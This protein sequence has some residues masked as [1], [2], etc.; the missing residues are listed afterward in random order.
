[1]K[2]VGAA[3]ELLRLLPGLAD[4][5]LSHQH[6]DQSR[7]DADGVCCDAPSLLRVKLRPRPTLFLLALAQYASSSLPS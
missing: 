2:D 3:F 6:P 5:V 7:A 1:M 4:V